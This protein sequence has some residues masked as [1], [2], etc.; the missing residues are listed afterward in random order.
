MALTRGVNAYFPCPICLVP[1]D[2]LS[3]L[4]Q[5]FEARTHSSMK[6]VVLD[7]RNNRYAEDREDLLKHY[8]LRNID[9]S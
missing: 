6:E 8:G 5:F 4:D 3:Q 1:E 7:A 2:L 9:V